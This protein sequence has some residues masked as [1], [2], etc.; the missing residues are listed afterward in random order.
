M[1]GTTTVSTPTVTLNGSGSYHAWR[2]YS[3][4]ASIQLDSG[5]QVMQ[6]QNETFHLN[7][8]FL[9]IA[10]DSGQFTT[11]IGRVPAKSASAGSLDISLAQKMVRFSIPDAGNV[12]LSLIDCSGRRVSEVRLQHLG[13]GP[14]SVFLQAPL[15]HNGVYLLRL[16]HNGIAVVKK[17][18]VLR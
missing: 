17:I 11:A 18:S 3:D 1:N 13:K 6:F 14:H 8:D 12:L 15:L 7:Q 9:Y 4:F 10:A 16:E 2:K 5:V